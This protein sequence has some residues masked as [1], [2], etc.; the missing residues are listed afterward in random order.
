MTLQQHPL[1][2]VLYNLHWNWGGEQELRIGAPTDFG[3]GVHRRTS[4]LSMPLGRPVRKGK[5]KKH[6]ASLTHALTFICSTDNNKI[7]RCH[8]IFLRTDWINTDTLNWPTKLCGMCKIYTWWKKSY[9]WWYDQP[10][11]KFLHAFISNVLT[12]WLAASKSGSL[13][14]FVKWDWRKGI[15]FISR[16]TT[17]SI[18]KQT[19][20]MDVCL[21]LAPLQSCFGNPKSKFEGV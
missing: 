19:M 9:T 4:Q 7:E 1:A 18:E 20:H 17:C 16:I 12:R 8:N 2:V 15:Q 11:H 14:T 6:I 10:I 21:F 5:R 3:A 13:Y